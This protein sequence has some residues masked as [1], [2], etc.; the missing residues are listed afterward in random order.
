MLDHSTRTA[1]LKLHEQGHSLRGIARAMRVSRGAVR[2][3]LRAGSAEVPRIERP[4][5]AAP[6]REAILELYASCKGNLVR[7]HEELVASGA[8]FSYQALTAFC[9]RQGIGQEVKEPVGRYSFELGQ[10]MQHDTSPHLIHL[11]GKERR[12]QT[13]SLVLCYSRMIFFQ[14]YPNFTRFHCKVFLT[15]ALHYLGGSCAT[16]MIDNTHLVV[17]QGTGRNMVPVPEMQA[18]GERYHFEFKAHE[19]GDANRSAHVE[20][21]FSYIEN[22]FLAGRTFPDWEDANRQAREWCDKVNGT[23]R[24]KL[25]ASARELLA[26]EQA[27]LKPLPVWVPPVYLLHQRIVDVEGYV[28]VSTNR[29]SVPVEMIGRRVEVRENKDAIEIYEGPRLIATHPRI[30]EPTGR[31]FTLP[32]HRRPRGRGVKPPETSPEEKILL[33]TLPELAGYVRALKEHSAGR[34]TVALRRLLTMVNDYPREPLRQALEEA[35]QYGLYDLDRVETVILRK[36]GREYFQIRWDYGDEHDGR[37]SATA[38]ESTPEK[39]GHDT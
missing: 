11:G 32:E 30:A 19:K 4:E 5:A 35:A 21:R 16:C 13:A 23:F 3:V 20:R 22:N 17:L 18:F 15:D 27:Y 25:K 31:H 10:E 39:D 37:N 28:S 8:D 33:E 9:R 36:L 24:T 38:G 6:Y 14:F 26:I 1:I 34:G 7:V 2:E 12:V 29:Y